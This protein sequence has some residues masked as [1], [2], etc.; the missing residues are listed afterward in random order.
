MYSYV[1]IRLLGIFV[2][3]LSLLIVV[4]YLLTGTTDENG[5]SW[6]L[7]LFLFELPVAS[8]S[9]I[10]IT[11]TFFMTENR[12]A[13][14][15]TRNMLSAFT[16]SLFF[17]VAIVLLIILLQDIVLPSLTKQELQSKGVKDIVFAVDKNRYLVVDKV[18]YDKKRSVYVLK[19]ADL[20]NKNFSVVGSYRNITYTPSKNTLAMGG[21]EIELDKNLETVLMFYTDRNYFFSIW[22]FNDV[23][24]AF[25]VFDIKTSFINFVMYEKIFIPVI[26]FVVMVFAIT[27][28]WRWRMSRDTKLM[29]LYIVVGIVIITVGIKMTYYLSI[30][31]FEYLV[32]PF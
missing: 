1:S 19:G 7:K 15:P 30:R 31:V 24:D 14:L 22:Q 9:S 13:K 25:L 16:P 2:L 10:V 4:S 17:T 21:R 18:E 28:G 3:I 8:T 26:T 32:F 6:F 12:L 27:F 11:Y 5:I 29:P 20:V 23:K